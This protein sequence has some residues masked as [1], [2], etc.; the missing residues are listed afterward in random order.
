M[1]CTHLRYIRYPTMVLPAI[2]RRCI[3]VLGALAGVK[4]KPFV[5]PLLTPYCSSSSPAVLRDPSQLEP[6]PYSPSEI[7]TVLEH[8]QV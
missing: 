1:V 4:A 8:T 7:V 3:F 6:Q 5:N 2:R